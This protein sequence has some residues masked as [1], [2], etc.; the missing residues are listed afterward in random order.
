MPN[1]DHPGRWS[2]LKPALWGLVIGLIA[3]P[4]LSGYFGWQVLADTAQQQVHQ[5]VVDQESKICALLAR[6][7]VQHPGK[8]EYGQRRDLA[9]KYAKLPWAPDVDFHV[10][11]AC[12][13]ALAGEAPP[14]ASPSH[15]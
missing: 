10:V 13:D 7:E 9:E 12:A 2:W 4:S 15:G 6:R 14:D 11:D 3:G 1:Q 5:A 8:L